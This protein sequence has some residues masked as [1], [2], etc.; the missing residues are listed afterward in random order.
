M[1]RKTLD[2]ETRT[3]GRLCGREKCKPCFSRSFASCEN[4]KYLKEGQGRPLLM[5]R[6]S[7]KKFWFEC[8]KCEHSFA[9]ELSSVSNGSFCPFCSNKQ[10]CSS[11][12]CK[13]CF[14]KSFASSNKVEFWS[15]EKNK[16]SPREVFAWSHKKY[17]LECERCKHSF[18]TSLD[19][20]SR[21]HFCPFCSSQKLCSSNKCKT[22]FEKSFASS[23]KAEFWSAE[24]NKQSPREVFVSSKK[25]FWFECKKCKHSFEAILSNISKGQFC[26]FCSNKALCSSSECRTCFKKSF[27]SSNKV[28][29]WSA[30]KN[31]KDPREMFFG[32]E[33]KFWFDCGKCSHSFEMRL[34][35]ISNGQFCPFCSN[36][37]LCPS[38]DCESCFEKSF[39]SSNKSEFWDFKK[40]K[41]TPRE[42]FA[43]SGK[44]FWFECGKCKHSFEAMLSNVSKGKFCPFCS[45][46]KLC[47]LDECKTCFEKSFA[48][49]NKTEFWDFEKNERKPRGVFAHSHEK[50]WFEC[51]KRHKFSSTLNSISSGRWCP[52]CKNKTEAKLL[53]F[54]EENFED[55]IHQF[56]VS[57]CKNPETDKFL[58]FD[59]CVSKTIIEL[60]GR[61]HY[62]QV[63]NWKSPEEQQKS[64]RYKEKQAIQNGYSVLRILQEDVWEDKIDWEKLLLEHIK[65]YE[66]PITKN[67]WEEL[68]D[69]AK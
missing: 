8:P 28:E 40:N 3:K 65:D 13:S 37:K 35:D 57:W 16:Q 36:K 29:F 52:K 67:L 24:K 7:H 21:G 9:M 44:K 66:T 45:N 12:E 1:G 11:D 60:D 2:C 30:E 63:M 10:L 47:F 59:F 58:P 49:S 68:P 33:K 20:V 55:P 62:K 17:W 34:G 38:P 42:V 48:S 6:S 69:S 23:D 39:A 54:L 14:E 26:P 31:K 53:K 46:N 18:E 43:V 19:G 22:C 15:V 5:A 61:Q 32:S 27:A 56:K 25:K 64:D 41:G 51:E 50:F 4:S